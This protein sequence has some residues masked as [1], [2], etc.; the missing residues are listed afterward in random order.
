MQIWR[1]HSTESPLAVAI[2]GP[3]GIPLSNADKFKI[4]RLPSLIFG[5]CLLI[6]T[7]VQID[8]IREWLL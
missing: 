6:Q 2:F 8:Q 3:H 5:G 4:K 1:L 7:V